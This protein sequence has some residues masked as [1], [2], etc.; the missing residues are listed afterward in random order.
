MMLSHKH[1]AM[2]RAALQA[3]ISWP[4][5]PIALTLGSPNALGLAGTAWVRLALCSFQMSVWSI[6]S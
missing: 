2:H 1:P 5:M 4:Q 3:G 6:S